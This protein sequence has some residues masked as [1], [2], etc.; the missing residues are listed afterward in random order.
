MCA[1]E[2]KGS[3]PMPDKDLTHSILS[4]SRLHGTERHKGAC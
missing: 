3:I 1:E 4:I 2:K